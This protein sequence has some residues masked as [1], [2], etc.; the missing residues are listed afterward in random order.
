VLEGGVLEGGVL[1]GGVL[2]GGVLEGGV[3][4]GG[5]L[6]DDESMFGEMSCAPTCSKKYIGIRIRN[7]I[8]RMNTPVR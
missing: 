7:P 5:V 4:E 6:E 3:L 1:E 2:E 8:V